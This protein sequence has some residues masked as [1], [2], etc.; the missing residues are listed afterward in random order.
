MWSGISNKT[1]CTLAC[2]LD[3]PILHFF[4]RTNAILMVGPCAIIFAALFSSRFSAFLLL[5][6]MMTLVHVRLNFTQSKLSCHKTG[7]FRNEISN[8]W[9]L[10]K[11]AHDEFMIFNHRKIDNKSSYADLGDIF[12][13]LLFLSRDSNQHVANNR[14]FCIYGTHSLIDIPTTFGCHGYTI[15]TSIIASTKREK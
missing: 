14:H 5:L 4:D 3:W 1:A 7:H 2:S 15:C 12:S 9:N 11:P 8:A 13:S 10:S 6:L